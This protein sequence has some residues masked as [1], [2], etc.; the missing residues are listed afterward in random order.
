M[1]ENP[2]L[3]EG[4]DLFVAIYNSLYK[5]K[6][7]IEFGG[8]KAVISTAIGNESEFNLHK[9]V[10]VNNHTS[11]EE[12]LAVTYSDSK[13]ALTW[14]WSYDNNRIISVH[15]RIWNLDNKLNKNI[16]V[17]QSGVQTKSTLLA[18]SFAGNVKHNPLNPSVRSR[19]G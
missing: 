2:E 11:L 16:R 1:L 17:G 12:F 10:L 19:R 7:F 18:S 14:D 9:N 5:N 4:E 6:Q 15:V 13:K 8:V 3:L